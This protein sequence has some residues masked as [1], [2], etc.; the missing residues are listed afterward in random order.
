[1]GTKKVLIEIDKRYLARLKEFEIEYT[2]CP[3][4]ESEEGFIPIPSMNL[5]IAKER[6]HLGKNWYEAHEAL[7]EKNLRMLT[8][9]EFMKFLNYLRENPSRE[10]NLV[11][12]EITQEK[13][14]WKAEWLDAYFRKRED[15]FYVLTGNK[16]SFRK[17]EDGRYILRNKANAEKLENSLMK[18]LESGISFDSWLK[19]PT[20]QGFPGTGVERPD[21]DKDRVNYWHPEN[22]RVTGFIVSSQGIDLDC[23]LDPLRV[24]IGPVFG[25]RA[26]R[27]ISRIKEE[28]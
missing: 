17:R 11:Y 24:D 18:E 12:K 19:N 16:A 8:I 28:S 27:V 26:A 4:Y 5:E 7:V 20:S 25:V 21:I 9:P 14:S 23:G 15:G 10:N 3:S 22:N 6:S 13:E 1:M 2:L